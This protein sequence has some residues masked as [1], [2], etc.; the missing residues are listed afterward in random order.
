MIPIAIVSKGRADNLT[1]LSLLKDALKNKQFYIF[2]EPD[3]VEEYSVLEE[4]H[5]KVIGFEAK[6]IGVED[7]V[8]KTF[9]WF[10]DSEFEQFW[11]LDDDIQDM[12]DRTEFDTTSSERD[13]WHLET[14]RDKPDKIVKAFE[15][16]ENQ[17]LRKDYSQM[18]LSY[19]Q[20]NVHF[21]DDWKENDKCLVFV[22][23]N[24]KYVDKHADW[25]HVWGDI[26]L[27]L[28]MIV[29]GKTNCVCYKYT[30]GYP[31]MAKQKGGLTDYYNSDRAIKETKETVEGFRSKYGRFVRSTVKKHH[32][33][34]LYEIRVNWKEAS[35]IGKHK[36][37]DKFADIFG[38]K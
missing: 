24:L 33:N 2:V 9:E 23:M 26:E 16:M 15:E 4:D 27:S 25:C 14:I 31:G 10:H 5:I 13:Y 36:V 38:G 29:Q 6:S 35:K 28:R 21:N 37:N 30:F 34:K 8:N 19:R 20:T 32:G 17:L 11:L 3:E 22:L 1:T 12:Y 18:G 7:A